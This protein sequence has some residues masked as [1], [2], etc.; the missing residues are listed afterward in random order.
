MILSTIERVLLLKQADI[1]A[2]VDP[3]ALLPLAR[4][5]EEVHAADGAQLIRQ[6][7][8]GDSLFVLIEGDVRVVLPE[9]GEV[10]RRGPGD[11]IGEMSVI[12]RRPRSA[13]C[14]ADGPVTA[15]KIDHALFWELFGEQPALAQGVVRVLADRLEQA[16]LSKG[17]TMPGEDPP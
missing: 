3:E 7:E 2:Q 8:F 15:L 1:F 11:V 6:G 13:D 12:R 4:L 17:A 9:R 5:A 10:A 14:I 16:H